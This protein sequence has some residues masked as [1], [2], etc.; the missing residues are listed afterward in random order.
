VSDTRSHLLTFDRTLSRP[1]TFYWV[2]E[3]E[4]IRCRIKVASA[5]EISDLDVRL[6]F[7][8]QTKAYGL[9]HCRPLDETTFQCEAAVIHQDLPKLELVLRDVP[10]AVAAQLRAL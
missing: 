5:D 8:G 3:I 6:R 10:E 9:V 2:A 7:R 1:N 4:S